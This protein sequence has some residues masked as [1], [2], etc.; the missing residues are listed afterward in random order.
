MKKR[1]SSL[2]LAFLLLFTFSLFPAQAAD[3][4]Y[5]TS[6]YIDLG[7]GYGVKTTITIYFKSE[8]T[9]GPVQFITASKD[10]T[11]TLNGTEIATITITA[12][13]S[14]NGVTSWVNSSSV[15][16]SVASGWTYSGE[17]ITNSGNTASVTA[18]LSRPT[19]NQVPVYT[20]ISCSAAGVIS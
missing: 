4:P 13:F 19:Y 10:R 8:N 14:Y 18:T 9:K 15:S 16:K 1:I 3:R 2:L 11:Y 6:N 17:N 5:V 12:T 7:N 20:S